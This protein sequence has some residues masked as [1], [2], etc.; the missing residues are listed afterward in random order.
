M[1]KA[2]PGVRV[3]DFHVHAFPD[4]VAAR[5]LAVLSDAYETE[6]VVDGTIS[7]L[8]ALMER[9]GL[10]YAVIQPVATKATQVEGINDWAAS[11]DDP[12]IIA[13]G[14]MHPDYPDIPRE[15]DRILALGLRGIKIQAT[16][17]GVFVDDPRMYPIYEAAQERLIILFHSGAELAEFPEIRATPQRIANLIKDFPKLDV[18]VA[19]MGGYLMWDESDEFLVGKNVYL[20]TSAC[21]PSQL[22]DE[23]FLNMIRRHSVERVLFATDMPLNEPVAEVERL[24]RIGLSDDEL[25]LVLSG[26]A[27]RLLPGKIV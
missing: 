7:G 2:A 23:R 11:I 16:W 18:V 4:A 10:D 24:A 6:P 5:A 20:D 14:S 13:F 8:I 1:P 27:R 25:E 17:Q 19:H 3:V 26:N 9:T 21:F 22:P 15:T 12:R